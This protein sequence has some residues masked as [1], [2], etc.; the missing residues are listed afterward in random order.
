M[1]PQ[2]GLLIILLVALALRVGLVAREADHVLI[3]DEP[4]YDDIALNVAQGNGF[5]AGHGDE[6]RVPTA[7]R[8]P[9]YVLFLA[10]FYRAFG[11]HSWPPMAAQAV[12]DVWSC[13]ITYRLARRWHGRE[14]PALLAAGLFA[15]YPLFIL[16]TTQIITETLTLASVLLSVLAFTEYLDRPKPASLVLAGLA[17]G[18]CALNKPQ[19]GAAGI[20]FALAAVPRLGWL[21]SARTAAALT[22]IVA[23]TLAPWIV[24]NARVFHAFVPGVTQGGISFWGG[25]APFENRAVGGLAEPWVPDSLRQALHRMGELERSRWFYRDG[26]RIV[27]EDPARY[28]ALAARKVVRLW[29][30][31]LFDDPPSRAS[32]L[33]A[34]VHLVLFVLAGIGLT[35]AGADPV[36]IRLTVGLVLYWTALHVP[37]VAQV[38][39]ALPC[40]PLVFCFA[41]AGLLALPPF[42]RRSVHTSAG[43]A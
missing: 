1:S 4:S 36:G 25:T 5:Q 29:F 11:H 41:T 8:G 34:A 14:A 18:V 7:M 12:L 27:R 16:G 37:F 20:V 33:L 9:A 26:M 15:V 35:R 19:L 6:P 40:L 24:R 3:G 10:G 30:N 28:A 22:L 31:V 42:A 13:W 38:R 17:L 43:L 32:L 39:Y 23:A 21:R 2:R